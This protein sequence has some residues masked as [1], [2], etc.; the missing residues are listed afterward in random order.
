MTRYLVTGGAGFIGSHLCEA[1]IE[2]GGE[3]YVIDDLSTGNIA[4]LDPVR[5]SS[6]FH[7]EIDSI[8]NERLLAEFIDR[9][10]VVFHLAA[11]VGVKLIVD[12]PV[13]T[14]ETNIYGTELVLKHATKKGKRVVLASTSEVY[15]KGSKE[16]F[17]EE[18]DIVFGATTKSRWSYG[19]SKAIDEFLAL[20]YHRERHVPVVIVRLFNTVGP[21]QVGHYGM[22]IPGFVGRA[23]AGEP[24]QVYGDGQQTRCFTYVGD[25]VRAL[26]Q[27]A[28]DDRAVGEVFNVGSEERVSIADLAERVRELVNPDVKIVYLSYEDA[29]GPGFEDILHRA[30]DI[31]KIRSLIG[32]EPTLKLDDIIR[33]VAEHMRQERGL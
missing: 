26:V 9:A 1:L 13:H 29:Y 5:E 2:K 33:L 30:P 20:S 27:L 6:R 11:A 8:T 28:H 14:I 25:V 21:R 31:S 3:V 19:C 23:L 7:Y 10:D 17:C 12:S 32:Y 18:D 15:G 24:I 16:Q 22:V 4:N